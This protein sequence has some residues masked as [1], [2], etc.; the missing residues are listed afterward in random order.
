M[1]FIP[2]G[3]RW[4]YVIASY[5]ATFAIMGL[6]VLASLHAARR[7]RRD[8]DHLERDGGPRRRKAE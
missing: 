8:L 5:A 2:E 1:G 3:A 6:L 4:G 7:A